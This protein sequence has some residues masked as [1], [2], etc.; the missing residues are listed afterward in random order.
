MA[1]RSY[2]Y[3]CNEIPG[4]TDTPEKNLKG[5]SE[6]NYAI[7]LA[8]KIMLMP[9]P[10][11]CRSRIW[12]S[13]DEIAIIG[14]FQAG[15]NELTGFLDR[16]TIKEAQP[17]IETTLE[18]LNNPDNQAQYLLLECGEIF[19]MRDTYLGKENALLL[20]KISTLRNTMEQALVK[21]NTQPPVAQKK[22]FGLF[23]RKAEP[24]PA[25]EES[26][27]AAAEL[28]LNNWSQYLHFD[29]SG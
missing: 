20:K 22:W 19:D 27:R 9:N 16:I 2:L 17:E 24:V 3:A 29:F 28:G 5:L 1:N 15:L 12:N 4:T 13:P 26:Q 11:T 14:D 10:R 21:I 25:S 23:P 18:F 8:Y 6:C 7:P